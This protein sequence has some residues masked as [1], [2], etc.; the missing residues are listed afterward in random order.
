M[1]WLS[2]LIVTGALAGCAA[3]EGDRE[4][5]RKMLNAGYALRERQ[6]Y[7]GAAR[8]FAAAANKDP[9]FGLAHME[10]GVEC[11]RYGWR[12]QEAAEAFTRAAALDPNLWMAAQY[13]VLALQGLGD[14]Q[15]AL[16]EQKALV[17]REPGRAEVH[18]NY[19][20][21]LL[22]E[23]RWDEAERCFRKALEIKSPYPLA[24]GGL[25]IALWHGGRLEEGIEHL[26]AAVKALPRRI[27]L[28]LELA[29]ALLARNL[30]AEAAVEAEAA[31]EVE[32][33]DGL[34]YHIL[35]EVRLAQGDR[36]A[37]VAMAREARARRYEI[38]AELQAE[39]DAGAS[40]ET[41]N[42]GGSP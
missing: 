24:R 38:S 41:G 7:G 26:R 4:E 17:E 42:Q 2:A 36:D 1:R 25:G 28:R 35:A 21:L 3:T 39:L 8:A 27:A 31:R 6:D 23:G 37:A 5:A 15:G 40:P 13:R 19:G 10:L 32:P 9:S 30:P 12:L 33:D 22:K 34:V 20:D 11:L 18:Q 16:A 29:R 14:R